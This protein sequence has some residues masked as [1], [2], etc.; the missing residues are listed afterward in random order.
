M[1]TN[2]QEV[3]I[4][5]HVWLEI[6]V[7]DNNSEDETRQVC[8]EIERSSD[9][10]I[11]YIFEQKEGKWVNYHL[12]RATQQQVVREL[13]SLLLKCDLNDPMIKSDRDKI[14][15]VDRTTLCNN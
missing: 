15:S 13:I 3:V 10:E 5:D 2:F 9:L 4:P 8:E 1:L 11:R 6:I 14:Q 7:V 12:N